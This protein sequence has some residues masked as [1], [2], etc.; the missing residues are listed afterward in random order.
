MMKRCVAFFAVVGPFIMLISVSILYGLTVWHFEP[1][2]MPPGD[3]LAAV[4]LELGLICFF[5]AFIIWLLV[6]WD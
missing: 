6:D 5:F 2:V 1:D 4:G 3:Q